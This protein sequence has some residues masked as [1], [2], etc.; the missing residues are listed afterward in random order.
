VLL[1]S[2]AFLSPDAPADAEATARASWRELG[3]WVGGAYGNFMAQGD[4]AALRLMYPPATRARLDRVK[5]EY[6]PQNLFRG[7]QPLVAA[8]G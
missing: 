5:A 3:E 7:N 1:I 8:A 4:E 2:A 6:D